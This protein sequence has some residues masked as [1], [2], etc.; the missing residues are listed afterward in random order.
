MDIILNGSWRTRFTVT[1]RPWHIAKNAAFGLAGPAL[2]KPPKNQA[3][4]KQAKAQE[5]QD[6]CD[7]NE[8]EGVFGAGKT[9]YGLGRI[10]AHLKTTAFCAIGVAL[11]LMNLTKRLRSLLRLFY[12]WLVWIDY[13]FSPKAAPPF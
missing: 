9:A 7:R 1:A 2:G 5:Y 11:I 3:L 8:V 10:A 4:T 6:S 13:L 12:S